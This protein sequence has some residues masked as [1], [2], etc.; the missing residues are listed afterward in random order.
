MSL[1]AGPVEFHVWGLCKLWVFSPLVYL[2]YT[3]EA[4]VQIDFD[5]KFLP[6]HT[7]AYGDQVPEDIQNMGMLAT[8]NFE[9]IKWDQTVL[10][11]LQTHLP[12]VSGASGSLGNTP[13]TLAGANDIVVGTFLKQCSYNFPFYL[14]RA[15]SVS[16]VGCETNVEGPYYFTSC[17]LGP[18]AFNVGTKNTRHKLTVNAI[19]NASGVLFRIGSS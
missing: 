18:D 16:N 2:G 5:P 12:G 9:L 3:S 10:Q 15:G 4:G 13:N 14:Q 17:Y 6:V 8:I 7:D 1:G 19:P 11:V